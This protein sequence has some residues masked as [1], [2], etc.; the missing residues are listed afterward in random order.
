M[1][2]YGTSI[3]ALRGRTTSHSRLSPRARE[4]SMH[5]LYISTFF[6]P[7]VKIF[8]SHIRNLSTILSYLQYTMKNGC[9]TICLDQTLY[10]C[11]ESAVLWYQELRSTLYSAGFTT[12]LM[13]PCVFNRTHNNIQTTITV[14]VDDL[15]ITSVDVKSMDDV[16]D[17]LRQRYKEE[18]KGG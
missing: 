13:D 15:I 17:I 18:K 7:K 1:Q 6:V 11:I 16:I 12:N 4:H 5:N 10:G 2:I 14:Y 3:P 9:I 8:S